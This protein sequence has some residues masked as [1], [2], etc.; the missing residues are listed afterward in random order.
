[1]DKIPALHL[2][3][4]TAGEFG[5]ICCGIVLFVFLVVLVMENLDD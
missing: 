3:P 1:M 4:Y 5:I 2:P